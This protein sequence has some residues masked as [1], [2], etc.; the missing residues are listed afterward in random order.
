MLFT[1]PRTTDTQRE[2]SLHCTAENSLPLPNCMVWRQHILSA[3]SAQFFRYL[4]FMPSLGVRSPWSGRYPFQLFSFM[5]KMTS[6]MHS[7]VSKAC[8]KSR[9]KFTLMRFFTSVNIL[10]LFKA[11]FCCKTFPTNIT[12]VFLLII[13]SMCWSNVLVHSTRAFSNKLSTVSAWYLFMLI[14]FMC[15]Q[16]N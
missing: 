6:F 5:T 14:F 8:K 4:W 10:V 16:I 3:T 15:L 7:Q 12:F 9:A 2:N 13:R 11:L 1:Y